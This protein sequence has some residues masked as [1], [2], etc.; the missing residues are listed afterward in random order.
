MAGC[1]HENDRGIIELRDRQARMLWAVLAI[2][3]VM[4]VV[5]FGAGWLASSTALLGD[6]L[7]MLGDALVYGFSLLV[8]ARSTRWKAISAGFKGS[9]MAV[10]GIIVLL[11][12]TGKILWGSE[13][14]ALLMALVG[15]VALAANSVCLALLTRHRGDDVNMR[16]AWICSRNDLVANAGVLLAAAAVALTGSAWPDILV[17]VAIAVLF[18]RSSLGVLDDARRTYRAAPNAWSSARHG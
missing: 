14:Q 13:P 16:S 10:F 11:E 9:I 8:V 7:D 15:G 1:C 5:E 3:A 18:L 17:G 12:A 6:S 2:N 4:F